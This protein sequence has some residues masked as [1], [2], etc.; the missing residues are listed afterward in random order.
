MFLLLHKEILFHLYL[1]FSNMEETRH[2][3]LNWFILIDIFKCGI[4]ET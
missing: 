2:A 3:A 4:L 1:R